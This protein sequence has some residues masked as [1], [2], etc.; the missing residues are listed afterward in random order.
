MTLEQFLLQLGTGISAST[1]YDFLKGRFSKSKDINTEELK[2]ELISFL[3]IKNAEIV[4][5]KIISFMAAN[6]DIEIKESKIFAKN[7]I[8]YSSSKG[9]KFSLEESKSETDKTK[10]DIGKK[11]K[12]E[13][14]GGAQIRQNEDGSISFRT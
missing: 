7:S 10:I 9:T 5:E 3:N 6:G 11:A 4:A 14:Q 13:G 2:Q 1:I 12:I 8:L